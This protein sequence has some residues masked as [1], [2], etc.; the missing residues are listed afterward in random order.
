MLAESQPGSDV[1][2]P[3]SLQQC[4]DAIKRAQILKEKMGLPKML[5]APAAQTCLPAGQQVHAN[6]SGSASLQDSHATEGSLLERQSSLPSQPPVSSTVIG[7]AVSM[8]AG[9]SSMLRAYAAGALQDPVE[10][11]QELEPSSPQRH[12][13]GKYAADHGRYA[14]TATVSTVCHCLLSAALALEFI[15][16]AVM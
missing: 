5:T 16:F 13:L 3:M 11:G 7:K 2:L 14:N 9:S 1:L 8:P 15:C 10:E 12:V 4:S 6:T